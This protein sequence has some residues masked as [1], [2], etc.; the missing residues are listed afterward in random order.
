MGLKSNNGIGHKTSSQY[1][2][3]VIEAG[4]KNVRLHFYVFISVCKAQILESGPVFLTESPSKLSFMNN[5]GA[6]LDCSGH[7]Y[8]QPELKWIRQDGRTVGES[9]ESQ[10]VQVYH[11]GS[12]VFRPFPASQY[13]HGIHSTS[14]RCQISNRHG[15]IVSPPVK[16]AARKLL[17]I[18]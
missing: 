5:R 17:I 12:L 10:L 18:Q 7:G 4:S 14:Y 8:P 13:D 2:N 11:N 16:V 6:V 3:D 1:F 9:Y 15:T